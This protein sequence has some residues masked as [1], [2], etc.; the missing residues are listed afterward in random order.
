MQL[1]IGRVAQPGLV[2]LEP[3]SLFEVSHLV[4]FVDAVACCMR[5]QREHA[6]FVLILNMDGARRA[7]TACD[8]WARP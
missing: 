8:C 2:E 3:L 4:P 6:S 7:P 5:C 1:N